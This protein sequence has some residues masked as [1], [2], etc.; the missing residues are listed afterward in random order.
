M[1]TTEK[2]KLR[3]SEF[4]KQRINNSES[5]IGGSSGPIDRDKVKKPDC[6]YK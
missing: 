5:I 2:K 4:L 3:L 1:K 6:R